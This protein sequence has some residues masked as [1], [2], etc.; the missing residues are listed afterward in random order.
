MLGTLDLDEAAKKAAGNWQHFDSFI[1]FRDRDLE[2]SENWSVIYTHHRDSTL[3][4]QSNAAVIAEALEALIRAVN[5]YCFA[6][7]LKRTYCAGPTGKE[8][9][10]LYQGT[11]QLDWTQDEKRFNEYYDIFASVGGSQPSDPVANMYAAFMNFVKAYN[12]KK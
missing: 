2:D 9:A 7:I 5:S 11:W 1:W 3:L 6:D 10:K 12:A 4:D 8:K